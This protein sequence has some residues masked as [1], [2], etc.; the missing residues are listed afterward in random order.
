M[1]AL[2]VLSDIR[3]AQ[4]TRR[5]EAVA[6]AEA[7]WR[8]SWRWRLF[9]VA[10]KGGATYV[11]GG[12]AAWASFALTGETAQIALWGG[13]LLSNAGPLAFGYAFW[14]REQGNW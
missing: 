10:M 2:L 7:E 11:A 4:E 3:V 6:A 1:P 13:L 14:M 5:A 8:R 9:W 12:V